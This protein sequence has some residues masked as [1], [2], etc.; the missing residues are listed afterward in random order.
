MH[1][2]YHPGLQLVHQSLGLSGVNGVEAAHGDHQGVQV[3]ERLLLLV[4]QLTAQ[5]AQVG[6]AALAVIQNVDGVGAA[7]GALLVVVPGGDGLN[8]EGGDP[9]LAQ[10]HLLY[11][12]VI[13]VLVAAQHL[14]GLGGD[15]LITRHAVRRIGVQNDLISLGFHQETGVAQPCQCH[16]N[17]SKTF[18]NCIV[19]YDSGEGKRNVCPE[20]RR[21]K[22]TTTAGTGKPPVVVFFYLAAFNIRP[23]AGSAPCIPGVPSRHHGGGSG[24]IR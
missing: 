8:G 3:F 5:V 2:D 22:N 14:V 12:M 6:D 19:P 1:G 9:A 10:R 23:P 4:G 21:M 15:G 16:N 20:Q 18:V 11:A 24:Y 13:P 7:Q 17:P